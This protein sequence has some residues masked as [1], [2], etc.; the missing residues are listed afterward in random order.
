MRIINKNE[1]L[2]Q[3]QP[4][5]GQR[6]VIGKTMEYIAQRC[7]GCISC[8]RLIDITGTQVINILCPLCKS[9]LLCCVDNDGTYMELIVVASRIAIL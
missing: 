6:D 1:T 2:E 8:V 4:C 5:L 7:Q 9:T 3:H